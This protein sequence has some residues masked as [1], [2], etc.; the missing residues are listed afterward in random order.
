M[1]CV[2]S[3][4]IAKEIEELEE[5]LSTLRARLDDDDASFTTLEQQVDAL[6]YRLTETRD[7]M[8]TNERRLADKR[9]ELA[10]AQRKEH[11]DAYGEEVDKYRAARSRVAGAAENFLNELESYDGQVVALRHLLDEMRDAFGDEDERVAEVTA[12]LAEEA[13]EL[14][15]SWAAVVDAAE[16]RVQKPDASS[17]HEDGGNAANGD[18]LSDELQTAAAEHRVS[19]IREYFNKG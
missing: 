17:P 12:A 9:V 8:R 18:D 10:A 19:R 3:G 11:L 15:T 2:E 6:R 13:D 5:E 16:W 14:N 7:S 4:A 1:A